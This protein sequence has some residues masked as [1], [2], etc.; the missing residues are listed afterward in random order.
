MTVLLEQRVEIMNNELYEYGIGYERL[1]KCME[2][3]KEEIKQ[4]EIQAR[5]IP[6]RRPRNTLYSHKR[7]DLNISRQLA[8]LYKAECK[9][10]VWDGF[11]WFW[12]GQLSK[13]PK[14]LKNVIKKSI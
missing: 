5:I 9:E 12:E 2:D 1:C 11:T 3:L 13:M 7:Y 14:C 6:P 8:P 4:V 10:I